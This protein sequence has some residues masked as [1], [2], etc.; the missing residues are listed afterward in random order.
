[1]QSSSKKKRKLTDSIEANTSTANTI[2]NEK[3]PAPD[4]F[5]GMTKV[6]ETAYEVWAHEDCVVWSSGVHIIG[7]RIIGLEAAVWCSTRHFCSICSKH[8]AVLSCLQRGCK[9]EAHVSCAKQS[10]WTLCE[11]S[12]KSRCAKHGKKTDEITNDENK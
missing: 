2:T 3:L 7:T 1:M 8:G 9:D 10:E 4:I 6:S 5:Y 12:F 11:Q